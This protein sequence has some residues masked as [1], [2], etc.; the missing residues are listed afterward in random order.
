MCSPPLVAHLDTE[1]CSKAL[2]FT[3]GIAGLAAEPGRG[4]AE[5]CGKPIREIG[6]GG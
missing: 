4:W 6:N 5:D 1:P 2:L 3:C